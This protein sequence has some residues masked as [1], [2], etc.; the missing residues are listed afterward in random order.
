MCSKHH[1]TNLPTGQSP[2]S[3]DEIERPAWPSI[4]E[5]GLSPDQ[6]LR[7]TQCVGGSDANTILS[8]DAD[9]V[10]QLWLEK[11][12]EMEPPDLSNNLAVALGSW[13]E[14][15]N[16][17][18]F[19]KITG[20]AVNMVGISLI[21]PTYPWR[22]CT[23]DGFLER[24]NAIW[25]AKHTSGFSRPE[26]IV[27]RYMP[28]LQHN[29][30]IAGVEKAVL[31]VIFGNH[32]FEIFEIAADW[33]YQIVLLE[34]EADF[35]DCVISGRQPIPALVPAPP[36]PVGVREICLE[37]N[38]AWA[39]AAA[40][41]LNTRHAAKVHATACTQLKDLLE[42]DVARAFGHGI[43]AKRSKVGAVTIRELAL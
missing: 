37:G 22:G 26:E 31:S 25:Q 11:R 4:N 19:E 6:I 40:D 29:M 34:A 12:S 1:V 16:R 8:G 32:K 33:I 9:R 23:L 20:Q 2:K 43:E 28:Q 36:K 38:N 5:L 24:T 39:C 17:Q 18:W 10:R 41:W 21:C 35:W 15:F 14:N 42:P 13:T 27:E 7:R 30:A 3:P